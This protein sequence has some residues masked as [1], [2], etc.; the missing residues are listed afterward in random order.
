MPPEESPQLT[1]DEIALVRAWVEQGAPAQASTETNKLS[2][3]AVRALDA[4]RS[5][6]PK[7]LAPQAGGCGACTVPGASR[8]GSLGSQLLS[9]L[10][11]AFVLGLRRKAR[12][13]ERLRVG[14]AQ[15]RAA[16]SRSR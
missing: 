11:V 7:G 2:P 10:A 1:P 13:S 4:R 3:D 9:L 12:P 14:K 8:Q 6:L 16:T 15:A 5:T